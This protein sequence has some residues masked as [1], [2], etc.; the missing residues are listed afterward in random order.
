LSVAFAPDGRGALAAGFGGTLLRSGDGGSSWQ[1][2]ASGTKQTL[3]SVAFAPDGRGALAVA[4]G[5]TLLRSGDGGSSWHRLEHKRGPAAICWL[6]WA[7]GFL[8]VFP[9]FVS[10]APEP[11]PPGDMAQIFATDRPLLAGDTDVAGAAGFAGQIASFLQNPRTEPPLTIAITG[12]WG[13]GKSSV[14]SRLTDALKAKGS[15]PVW[16]NA[17]HHQGEE[18][19]FAACSRRFGGTLCR[20]GF[21]WRAWR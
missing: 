5:G 12:A 4:T 9:S 21:H 6:L 2:V 13:S 18:N 20:P 8:L 15:R 1:P 14:L 3:S 17:W 16:F 19:L 7:L 10:L 11:R